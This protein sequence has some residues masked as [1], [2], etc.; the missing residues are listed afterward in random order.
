MNYWLWIPQ[1]IQDWGAE[2]QE[3]I[4]IIS[5]IVGL[6]LA[7][8]FPLVIHAYIQYVLDLNPTWAYLKYGQEN[9]GYLVSVSKTGQG[10]FFMLWWGT[11][12]GRE[13]KGRYFR[14]LENEGK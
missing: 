4:S 9:K 12:D 7:D 3:Q 11:E 2:N 1:I 14:H 10:K 6:L 5:L 13:L 8:I